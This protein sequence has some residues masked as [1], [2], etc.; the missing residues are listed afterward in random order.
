MPQQR[1]LR[2]VPGSTQDPHVAAPQSKHLPTRG[3]RASQRRQNTTPQVYARRLTLRVVRAGATRL[4]QRGSCRGSR[5]I[6]ARMTTRTSRWSAPMMKMTMEKASRRR[7]AQRQTQTATTAVLRRM[8]TCRGGCRLVVVAA[9][10]KLA[11]KDYATT[12]A[13]IVPNVVFGCYQVGRDQGCC[14]GDGVPAEQD[15]VR[16]RKGQRCPCNG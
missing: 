2:F 7:D 12:A 14:D 15:V 16:C 10:A 9:G 1:A 13:A 3:L 11:N 4:A 5:I 8:I 6:R